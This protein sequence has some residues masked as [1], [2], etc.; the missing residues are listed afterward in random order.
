MALGML[1]L[2][3]YRGLKHR[4]L[5]SSGTALYQAFAILTSHT[6][7]QMLKAKP[8]QGVQVLVHGL[9]LPPHGGHDI[10]LTFG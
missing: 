5:H 3:A 6:S 8:P 7:P 4:Y 9:Q 1:T 2:K 10:K